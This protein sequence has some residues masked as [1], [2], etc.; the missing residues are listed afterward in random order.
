MSSTSTLANND[1]TL[2]LPL[3][4]QIRTV[5]KG[6]PFVKADGCTYLPHPSS[7][8]KDPIRYDEFLANA[9][10]DEFTAHT[11]R[12]MIGRMK[13]DD[14]VF[15]PENRLSYL[16][17]DVDKDGLSMRGLAESCCK[18]VME[19]GFHILLCDYKG[20]LDLKEGELPSKQQIKDANPRPT[21]KQYARENLIDWSFAR[22]NG[23]RQFNYMLLTESR[24]EV[25]PDTG[26]RSDVTI[27]LKLGLDD[28]GYFQQKIEQ[29]TLED[30][31]GDWGEKRYIEVNGKP[32]KFIPVSIAADK[33]VNGSLPTE[34]GF[35]YSIGELALYRYRMSG[36][37]KECLS[38]LLPTLHVTGVSKTDWEDFELINGRAT[39]ASGVFTPN[40]WSGDNVNFQLLE[41]SQSLQQF[42][43][44]FEDNKNKVRALGGSFKTDN[45]VQRTATEVIAESESITAILSPIADNVESAIAWQI[46]YC[47]MFEGFIDQMSI[48]DYVEIIEFSLN[49]EFA[50]SKLTVDEIKAL[51]DV[52]LSG[53]LPKSEFLKIMEIGGRTVSSAEE[54]LSRLGDGEM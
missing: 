17:Q 29:S 22:I 52:H 18:N 9:E 51:L 15:T 1:Y 24:E 16:A 30:N 46:A 11:E 10:F 2:T 37:Y 43:D 34:L 26:E 41:S 32:L 33:E 3:V 20:V 21:I 31:G 47:A 49:K 28:V 39:V 40:I 14:L 23:G 7:V 13:L 36:K 48:A 45:T 53:L 54:L 8:D 50:A 12:V 6:S 38:N 4:T 35:L 27:Y 5:I 25:N 44:F 42:L 19:V